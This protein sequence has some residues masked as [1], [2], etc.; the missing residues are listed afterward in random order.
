[1]A[2]YGFH[3]W[4]LVYYEFIHELKYSSHEWDEYFNR[5]PAGGTK[6]PKRKTSIRYDEKIRRFK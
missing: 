2:P 3:I 4:Y 6:N 1:M 5:Y